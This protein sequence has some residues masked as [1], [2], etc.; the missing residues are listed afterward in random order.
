MEIRWSQTKDSRVELY[1]IHNDQEFQKEKTAAASN[2][3]QKGCNINS[4]LRSGV[5]EQARGK[6]G[7]PFRPL[8]KWHEQK[9]W[10]RLY[11]DQANVGTKEANQLNRGWTWGGG[12]EAASLHGKGN[13]PNR[14]A[15]IR[16]REHE[17][18]LRD[19]VLPP[20]RT[21]T[22]SVCSARPGGRRSS[23]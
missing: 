16:H 13:K 1:S 19:P 9:S 2:A 3:S 20:H 21:S 18:V 15:W 14:E 12:G 8:L 10:R 11:G 6:D 7:G 17:K 22:T 4:P 5:K 23:G